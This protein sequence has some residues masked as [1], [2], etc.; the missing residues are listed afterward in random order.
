MGVGLVWA[1]RIARRLSEP[2]WFCIGLMGDLELKS[3][4]MVVH[5]RNP[6]SRLIASIGEIEYR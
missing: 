2:V 5:R 6:A 3:R 4:H 1:C